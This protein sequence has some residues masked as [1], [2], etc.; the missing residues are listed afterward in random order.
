MHSKAGRGRLMKSPSAGA[1]LENRSRE[2]SKALLIN[3]LL[4]WYFAGVRHAHQQLEGLSASRSTHSQL[5]CTGDLKH[6]L[7]LNLLL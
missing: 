2:K 3:W 4:F 5:L 1:S 6:S 7:P